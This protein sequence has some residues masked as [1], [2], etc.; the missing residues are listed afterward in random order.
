MGARWPALAAAIGVFA[1]TTAAQALEPL[2]F[3]QIDGWQDDD[4]DAALVPFRMSC[5]AISRDDSFFSRPVQYGGTRELWLEVCK[6]AS[7]AA[8]ARSFFETHFIPVR[9]ADRSR[10]EG[11]FTGYYEPEAEGRRER[12]KGFSIPI[13]ARPHDLVVFDEDAKRETGLDYGR[14]VDGRPRPYFTRREIENGALSGRGLEIVWLRDA[15]DAFFMQ[16][17]GS[18]RIRLEDGAVLRLGFAGKS[19]HPYTSIGAILAERGLIPRAELSMQAIRRWMAANHS[20]ARDLMWENE[21]F[22]FFREM[23]TQDATLGP[24]GAGRVPLTPE[25]SLA[26][27]RSIWMFGTPVWLDTAVPREAG[28]EARF[29]KLLIAQDTGSAIKGLARG[30]VFWGSGPGAAHSAGHM[31]SPGTM[32]VLLP[33]DLLAG[34]GL[35]P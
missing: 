4:L 32:I 21:S 23:E 3:R 1:M 20:E 33:K 28:G 29:R 14:V 5:A 17:Q 35:L 25:R 15:A 10:P 16:I 9:V 13:Y 11:L 22:V 8:D 27:D 2:S 7:K 6:A 34:L 19:G 24:S 31:K 18:G 26:V 12:A 30:D